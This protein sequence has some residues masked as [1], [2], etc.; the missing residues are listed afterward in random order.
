MMKFSTF[1]IA[2]AALALPA[3]ANAANLLTNGSF[4]APNIGSSGFQTFLAGSTGI[5]GWTVTSGLGNASNGVD[6]VHAGIFGF[7]A[8]ADDGVQYLDLVAEGA[9]GGIKQSFVTTIGQIYNIS[10]AYSHNSFGGLPSASAFFEI[11]GNSTLFPSITHSSGNPNALDWQH[12][13]GSFVASS[14]LST[15]NFI[16]TAGGGN[17]GILLDT[18]SVS[19]AV[20]EPAAW[21]LMIAGFGLVGGAMRRRRAGLTSLIA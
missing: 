10:F 12:F 6:I 14:S 16:N 2:A 19:G 13:S 7:V 21:A 18:V 3:S 8:A 15:L 4:E 1:L 20:P 9:N 11:V 17:A 5:A